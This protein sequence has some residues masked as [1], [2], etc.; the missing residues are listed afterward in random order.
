[1]TGYE[2]M[3]KHRADDLEQSIKELE[4]LADNNSHRVHFLSQEAYKMGIKYAIR[5]IEATEMLMTKAHKELPYANPKEA[6]REH[7]NLM[8]MLGTMKYGLENRFEG[9]P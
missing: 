2:M 9:K 5:Q 4:R 3:K 8:R 7:D 6:Q 1:M